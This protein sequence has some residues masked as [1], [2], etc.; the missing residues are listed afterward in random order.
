MTLTTV[1]R[2]VN[3][4]IDFGDSKSQ[5]SWESVDNSINLYRNY[6]KSG[7]FNVIATINPENITS[8]NV[9]AV[10]AHVIFEL[11]CPINCQVGELIKCYIIDVLSNAN[12]QLTVYFGDGEER[13]L[14]LGNDDIEIEKI[15][16]FSGLFSVSA[17]SI[18]ANLAKF[19][20]TKSILVS[21]SNFY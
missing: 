19:T 20:Q 3:V 11:R 16:S 12:V 10:N 9:I 17:I 14:Y 7:I 8:S 13:L 18:D 2:I 4:S 21:G 6:T 15:F 1:G 5:I